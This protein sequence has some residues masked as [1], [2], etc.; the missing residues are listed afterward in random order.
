MASDILKLVECLKWLVKSYPMVVCWIEESG[1]HVIAGASELHLDVCLKDL[2][3]DFMC[4][5]E[6]TK[7]ERLLSFGKLF[8]K[9]LAET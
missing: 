1:E 3:S 4:E 5:V 9:C 6:V 7:F 2:V 8:L